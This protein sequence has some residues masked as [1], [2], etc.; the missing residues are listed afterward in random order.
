MISLTPNIKYEVYFYK[1]KT[2]I[3][4]LYNSSI[5]SMLKSKNCKISIK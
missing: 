3:A 4:H 2:S 1:L 5:I